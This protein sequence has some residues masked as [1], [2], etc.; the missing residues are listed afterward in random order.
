MF[1]SIIRLCDFLS[2]FL[3]VY[4]SLVSTSIKHFWMGVQHLISF[5]IKVLTATQKCCED[6]Q[7]LKCVKCCDRVAV[8]FWLL[9][10][11]SAER[12]RGK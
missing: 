3:I 9:C 1:G 5:T 12:E 6:T 4:S 11:N 10:V 8:S 7:T 2:I